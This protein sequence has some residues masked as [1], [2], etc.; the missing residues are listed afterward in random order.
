MSYQIDVART[1]ADS[2][3]L[4]FNAGGISISTNC[5]WNRHKKIP[6][7][8]YDGCSATTMQNKLNTAGGPR[9]AIFIPGVAGFTGIFI[10]MGRSPYE[11]WSDGCIVIEESDM[12]K[13]YN[14][15]TP[16][17]GHNVTVNVS[18]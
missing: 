13:I 7:G 9:E 12:L 17:D 1:T 2:G 18:G 14:A 6:R 4:T 8:V 16:K 15:I 5:Y 11:L 10:H 3:T